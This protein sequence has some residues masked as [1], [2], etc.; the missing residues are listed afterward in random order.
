MKKIFSVI[1]VT[2]GWLFVLIQVFIILIGEQLSELHLLINNT[3]GDKL[4]IASYI[5]GQ[6]SLI[7]IG[8]YLILFSRRLSDKNVPRYLWSFGL[9]SWLLL[10]FLLSYL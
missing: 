9:I 1:F 3:G 2:L 5:S 6:L 4:K 10:V 7:L 8:F